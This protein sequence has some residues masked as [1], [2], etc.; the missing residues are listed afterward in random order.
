MLRELHRLLS[1]C[2]LFWLLDWWLSILRLLSLSHIVELIKLFDVLCEFLNGFLF[3]SRFFPVF[4][5]DVG[6]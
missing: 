3:L 1:G 4:T 2:L 5:T 6:T